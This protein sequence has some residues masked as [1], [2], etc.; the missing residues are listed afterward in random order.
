MARTI[1]EDA[2]AIRTI[3]QIHFDPEYNPVAS[4]LDLPPAPPGLEY[5]WIRTSLANVPDDENVADARRRGWVLLDAS[6]LPGG[7]WQQDDDPR[8][9]ASSDVTRHGLVAMKRDIRWR[10]REIEAARRQA[11][12]AMRGVDES[13]FREGGRGLVVD[14]PERETEAPLRSGRKPEF[15]LDS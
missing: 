3:E 6:E 12:E 1:R 15:Q 10:Q 7:G 8:Q 9:R 5:A 4:K 2:P 14:R 13:M 11:H